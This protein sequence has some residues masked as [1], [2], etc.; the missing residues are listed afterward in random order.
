MRAAEARE[1][2]HG[3]GAVLRDMQD[4][5]AALGPGG[6]LLDSA[7]APASDEWVTVGPGGLV[8]A[9]M[10]DPT[11]SGR[12]TGQ[13]SGLYSHEGWRPRVGYRPVDTSGVDAMRP[14]GQQALIAALARRDK[15]RA[16]T[17]DRRDAAA[18]TSREKDMQAA[19]AAPAFSFSQHLRYQAAIKA[20]I[21]ADKRRRA[22]VAK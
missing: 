17:A 22:A 15:A 8:P 18:R 6:L 16:R 2:T 10:P 4:K 12:G 1:A 20:Y 5:A 7:P 13:A 19:A 3:D 11:A 9:D 14:P 21:K